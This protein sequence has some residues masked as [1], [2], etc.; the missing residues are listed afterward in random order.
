[1]SITVAAMLKDELQQRAWAQAD[2]GRVLGWS[3]QTVSEVM[4]GKR[5]LE[6]AMALELQELTG[7]AA[8]EW[9]HAQVQQDLEVA[10]RAMGES[11]RLSLIG[12]RAEAE[13]LV[14]V[15][16]LVRRRVVPM[17]D[18]ES[19]LRAIRALVGEDAADFGA[20]AKRSVT[21][22]PFTRTQSAWVALVRQ[23]ARGVEVGEYDE[24]A[25][26]ELARS[27]PSRVRS[28]DGLLGLPEV[29]ADAGVALVHVK[30]LP[31]GRIDGVSLSVGRYPAIGLSG[32][33]RR[34]DK[35][36]FA[37]LHECAHVISGHWRGQPRVHEAGDEQVV[38]DA[39]V[40]ES[41]NA[42]AASWAFPDGLKFSG[43]MSRQVIAQLAAQHQV[44]PAVVVGHLQ[45]RGVL[46]WSSVLGRALPTADEALMT[47]P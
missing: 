5:K 1:M 8:E 13:R 38:G 25:F 12:L 16:E 26:G 44:A 17:A 2:L 3:V 4:Q 11:D 45:H 39:K 29:F 23:R 9:L 24:R 20:S 34:L 27:L 41:M 32:R 28:T 37:L 33:G 15:R 22:V 21:A 43:P 18:P 40:E 36:L 6:P 35:V 47:W 42:L 10:R 7:R 30:S 31:G 14:P 19:Q 46:E